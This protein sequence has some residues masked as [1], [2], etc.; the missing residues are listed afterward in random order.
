MNISVFGV[1]HS[2]QVTGTCWMASINRLCAT[3]TSSLPSMWLT[4]TKPKS[5]VPLV[6]GLHA[7][8]YPRSNKKK[9]C[10]GGA[11]VARTSCHAEVRF[12][13]TCLYYASQE[14]LRRRLRKLFT[15]HD[16]FHAEYKLNKWQMSKYKIP[17]SNHTMANHNPMHG[18]YN[19]TN[20]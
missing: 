6:C 13:R 17:M 20:Q 8:K 5:Y 9:S 2:Y 16:W 7:P 19:D 1:I 10:I 15:P 3:Y 12:F 14:G 18:I 11:V 4:Q